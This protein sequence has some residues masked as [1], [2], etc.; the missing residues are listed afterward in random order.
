MQRHVGQDMKS[1]RSQFPDRS[2]QE[3][4]YQEKDGKKYDEAVS[5]IIEEMDILRNCRLWGS[6]MTEIGLRREAE[7]GGNVEDPE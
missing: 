6:A 2:F 4:P 1:P 7:C 5:V 3:E